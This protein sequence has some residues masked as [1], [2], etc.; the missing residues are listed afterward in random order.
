MAQRLQRQQFRVLVDSDGADVEH[1]VTVLH[2]DQIRAEATARQRR[3]PESANG[4]GM[5][6]ASLWVWHAMRR[7]NLTTL[8][9]PEWTDTVYNIDTLTGADGEPETV[10]VAPTTASIG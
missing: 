4:G 6:R 9:Y 3:I 5:D 8:N 1:L 7:Q 10:D 2:G